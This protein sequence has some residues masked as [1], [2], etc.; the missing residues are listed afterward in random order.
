MKRIAN[1][2]NSTYD[3]YFSYS[4][5]TGNTSNMDEY[6]TT[7]TQIE[8]ALKLAKELKRNW[9]FDAGKGIN[10]GYYCVVDSYT[11]VIAIY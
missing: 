7:R 11:N 10:G 8:D 5:P 6:I 3:V 4:L 9:A 2:K 1:L